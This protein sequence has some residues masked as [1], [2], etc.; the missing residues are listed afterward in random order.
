MRFIPS[1]L[2]SKSHRLLTALVDSRH[3]KVYKVKNCVT[4]IDPEREKEKR[5][6]VTPLIRLRQSNCIFVV[7]FVDFTHL[8]SQILKAESQNLKA[9]TKLSQA[10]EKIKRKYPLPVERRQL[11][12]GYLE[13][14]LDEV[15]FISLCTL[16]SFHF[17]SKQFHQ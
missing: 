16:C 2:T 4:D 6:K 13:D 9:S 10:R 5:E 7:G 1:S 17:L 8:I 14:A 3:K 12:T 11:S 15:C